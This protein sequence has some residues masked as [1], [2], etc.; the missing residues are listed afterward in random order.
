MS[1]PAEP[2]EELADDVESV[3][4]PKAPAKLPLVEPL[5]PEQHSHDT[6]TVTRLS[7]VASVTTTMTPGAL[8]SRSSLESANRMVRE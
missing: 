5:S 8:M 2:V 6:A 3:A 1:L 4:V 7:T